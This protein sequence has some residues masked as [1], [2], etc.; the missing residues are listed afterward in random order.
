MWYEKISIFE[1]I[2]DFIAMDTVCW[3]QT[4]KYIT[5]C[6]TDWMDGIIRF[7]FSVFF[8]L[9]NIYIVGETD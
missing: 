9:S 6:N 1:S 7:A 2:L 5:L 3:A 8:F 4:S